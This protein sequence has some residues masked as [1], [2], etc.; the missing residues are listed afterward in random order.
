M[1]GTLVHIQRHIALF[2]LLFYLGV[3]TLPARILELKNGWILQGRYKATVPSTIMGVLTDNGEYDGILEGTAYKQIDRTRFDKP[4]TYSNTF[5][6]TENDRKGHVFLKLDGI[7]YRA[8]IKLNGVLIA[9]TSVV[10]GTYRRYLLDITSVAK[11]KN[12]LQIQVYRA[13]PGEPNAGYVDWNPRPAD[14]SMGIIRPVSIVTCGDVMLT[15]PAVFSEVN[16]ATLDEAWLTFSTKITNLSD[17]EVHGEIHASFGE[18]EFTYPISLHAGEQRLLTLTPDQVKQLH[19]KNPRLWWCRGLGTPELYKMDL[20]FLSNGKV[21]DSKSFQFGI[22]Q[23]GEYFTSDGDRGFTLNGKRVLIRGGGWTDDIF[24]RDTPETNAEQLY[25]VCDMNLNAIRMENIWGKSQDIFNRCDSLGI[26]VLPGWTCHWE[27]EVYLGKPCDDL[28]GCMTSENDIRLMTQYFHDQLLWL[29]HHPS[30]ICWFVGSDKI[31]VPKLEQNYQ[32]LLRRFDPSRSIVTSAK[33]LESQLSGTAG[34]KMEG[35]YD[36]VG[37]AY[38]YAQEAPGGAFGFNTETGIGAQIPQKESLKRMIGKNL[39]PINETWEYHCTASQTSMNSLNHLQKVISS[40][41]GTPATLDDFLHK[42]DLANYEST[43]AMFEAFRVNTPRS[44]GIVQWML[45][46]ARPGLYWQ[47]YDYYGQPNASYYSVKKGNSPIQLIYN[48]A[49]KKIV[50]VNE[51]ILPAHVHASMKIYS[52]DGSLIDEQSTDI[53]ISGQK[54]EIIFN[55]PEIKENAFLFLKLTDA[56]H[57]IISTNEY[58]LAEQMDIYDW[59]ATD[60]ITTPIKRYADYSAL[61]KLERLKLNFK[62]ESS[63]NVEGKSINI[64]VNNPNKVVA[65]LIRLALTDQKG[66]LVYPAYYTDNFITLQPGENRN[67]RCNLPKGVDTKD[68]KLQADGWNLAGI[69]EIKIK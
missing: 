20:T 12:A 69:S 61:A 19:I 55:T 58:V 15:S 51:S 37:P 16:M 17:H 14:E 50:A 38:W 8:N 9:D 36:Y 3:T 40:R 4:W 53:S 56:K 21:Q 34:M 18:V 62:A 66:H 67:I 45:N 46:S 7:S 59:E 48:Y 24:M 5:S 39:W 42:A 32:R 52:L 54:H 25:K 6:L 63:N 31:P 1:K 41:Y 68:L 57:N 49:S 35:P 27:W 44:T 64:S 29:R 10:Y 13:M 11:E 65:L 47:L 30:I 33:K 2:S 60:W 26:M 28:Y 22:R 43:K 23:V